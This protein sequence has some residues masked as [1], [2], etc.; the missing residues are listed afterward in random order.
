MPYQQRK[1]GPISD[2]HL[3]YFTYDYPHETWAVGDWILFN[4][5][6][7]RSG[8]DFISDPIFA[9]FVGFSVYDMAITINYVE[10]VPTALIC[11]EDPEV[12]NIVLWSDNALVLG[13]WNHKPSFRELKDAL[14][15]G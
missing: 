9:M 4:H 5:V 8:E 11:E 13:H 7:R 14:T 2:E 3:P 12:K 10:P 6:E 1:W 15:K